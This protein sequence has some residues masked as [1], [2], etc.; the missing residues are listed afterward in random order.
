MADNI[1]IPLNLTKV[2]EVK[3]TDDVLRKFL[4]NLAIKNNQLENE[5][6]SIKQRLDAGGL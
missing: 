4:I 2:V 6:A 3:Y 1:N 5:I